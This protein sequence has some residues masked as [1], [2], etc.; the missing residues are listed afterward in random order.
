MGTAVY[1]QTEASPVCYSSNLNGK[2]LHLHSRVSY[3]SY[4]R[5]HGHPLVLDGY[6]IEASTAQP[7]VLPLQWPIQT[8]LYLSMVYV[9]PLL[10]VGPFDC[11][12]K[13]E[14]NVIYCVIV[15]SWTCTS[16]LPVEFYHVIVQLLWCCSHVSCVQYLTYFSLWFK[17]LE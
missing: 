1:T 2:A 4:F 12:I 16:G 6:I 17:L 15:L 13:G 9:I 7:L 14:Y 10:I 11:H 8:V 5:F 3:S